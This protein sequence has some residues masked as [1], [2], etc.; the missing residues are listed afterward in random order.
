MSST[1]EQ[2]AETP[3]APNRSV[4][5]P[6]Q[7]MSDEGRKTLIFAGSA[8]ACLLITGAFELASRPETITEYG[9]VGEEFYPEFADPTVA[10]S[11]SVKVIDADELRPLEFSVE[12]AANGRWVIPSHHGYQAD[13]EDR[14][15]DTAS[16]VIG[17]KRGAMVTRWPAD[18]ARYGVVDPE[19]ESVGVDELDGIG[20]RLTL[21]GEDDSVL[22]SYIIGKQVDDEEGQYYVRHP[23]EDETYIADLDISLST[24]FTDWINTDLLDINNFDVRQVVLNDYSF[25]ERGRSLAVTETVVSELSRETSSDDWQL[26]SIDESKE[27]DQDAIRETVNAVADLELAGVRPK[28]PGLGGDLTLDRSVVRSQADV[29]RLQADLLSR[30]FLLQPNES[31]PNQLR[32]I[33]R[34]GE[35]SVGAEDGLKYNL[36]FG[37]VFTGSDEELEIGFESGDGDDSNEPADDGAGESPEDEAT[38]EET[39]EDE[40]DEDDA[41]ASGKPGRYV[42]IR[43]EVDPK[44]LGEVPEP[45][46]PEMPEELK[47]AEA[48]EEAESEDEDGSEED[49]DADESPDEGGEDSD[50]DAEADDKEEDEE[51][52]KREEELEKLRGEFEEAKQKYADDQRALKEYNEKLEEAKSKAEELNRRFALWYYVI[53]GE[54]Y[55][56]LALSREDLVKEKAADEEAAGVDLSDLDPTALPSASPMPSGLNPPSTESEASN[57]PAAE[58]EKEDAAESGEP[59]S[60][61]AKSGEAD[62]EGPATEQPESPDSGGTDTEVPQAEETETADPEPESPDA[63]SQSEESPETE[64]DAESS[65]ADPGGA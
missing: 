4:D 39:D 38:G 34:E 42:F 20:K 27:V 48:A 33:S 7:E 21:R 50:A 17:I 47:E 35:V 5:G 3:K 58:P 62:A 22:A 40:A 55:D 8:V 13:A 26:E 1:S 18:H 12:Q 64:A 46:E 59:K 29:D 43:V 41:S 44:L 36:H 37:R 6:R 2:T 9:R 16:S 63:A 23:A 51:A 32:L 10:K 45:V 28:Q 24:K 49:T 56:K 52:K 19:T 25:E 14:L 31:D 60:G 61:E 54:S 11:L 57:D 15:A 65:P 30:G 53:P